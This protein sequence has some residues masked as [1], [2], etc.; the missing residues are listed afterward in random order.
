MIGFLPRIPATGEADALALLPASL[1]LPEDSGPR[2]AISL[3]PFR[4]SLT[5]AG[6]FAFATIQ[7]KLDSAPNVLSTTRRRA[8]TH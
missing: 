2:L 7:K 4:P 3:P 5:A 6:S 8:P 1:Y